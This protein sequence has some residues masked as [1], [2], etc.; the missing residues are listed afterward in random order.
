MKLPSAHV[1]G[2]LLAVVVV[3]LTDDGKAL[4]QKAF[5]HGDEGRAGTKRL[6]DM[7]YVFSMLSQR[8]GAG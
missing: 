2:I 7:R 3:S 5:T 4:L 8:I 1:I 6:N